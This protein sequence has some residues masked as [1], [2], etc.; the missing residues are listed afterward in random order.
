MCNFLATKSIINPANTPITNFIPK[1]VNIVDTGIVSE[2]NIGNI[3][4]DV[5]K[6]T[7]ISVPSVITLAEYKFVA[8]TENP[9]CGTIPTIPP[10]NGPNFPDFCITCFTLLLVLC[11]IYSIIRYVINKNGNNFI[12]SIAVSFNTSNISCMVLSSLY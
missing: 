8:D 1:I 11:S 5:V 6:Y 9:H 3:S 4:S 12:L 7:E 2:I 10:N